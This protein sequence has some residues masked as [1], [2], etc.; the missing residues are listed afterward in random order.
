MALTSVSKNKRQWSKKEVKSFVGAYL[1][2]FFQL[3]I[4][5]WVAWNDKVVYWWW[6][7]RIGPPSDS[8]WK[9]TGI[10]NV[11]FS[12]LL[13]LSKIYIRNFTAIHFMTGWYWMDWACWTHRLKIHKEQMGDY[14]SSSHLSFNSCSAVGREAGSSAR[15]RRMNAATPGT[16]SACTVPRPQMM[17]SRL[18]GIKSVIWRSEPFIKQITSVKTGEQV[19]VNIDH[20]HWN[21]QLDDCMLGETTEGTILGTQPYSASVH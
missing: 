20:L 1:R 2:E 19:K 8:A 13:S 17:S 3:N 15:H 5:L 12:L 18:V 16:S 9:Q 7:Q 21:I 6:Q 10:V 14:R 4:C 11:S